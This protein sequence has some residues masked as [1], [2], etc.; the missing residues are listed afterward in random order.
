L[1]KDGDS[2]K[3]HPLPVNIM[4]AWK[5]IDKDDDD[6]VKLGAKQQVL[7]VLSAFNDHARGCN[8][9]S[10]IK[11]CRRTNTGFLE[12]GDMQTLLMRAVGQSVTAADVKCVQAQIR[13]ICKSTHGGYCRQSATDPDIVSR[14]VFLWWSANHARFVAAPR[15]GRRSARPCSHPADSRAGAAP[16]T[17]NASAMD[18]DF[19]LQSLFGPPPAIVDIAHGEPDQEPGQVLLELGASISGM[20]AFVQRG[21][22][23]PKVARS[24]LY[25]KGY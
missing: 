21:C 19:S 11:E 20:W 3:R 18:R 8:I 17:R 4:W 14:A 12:D 6:L 10:L 5:Q 2:N 25:K 13:S 1:L 7:D 15:L 22:E 16:A 9:I 23:A 24:D